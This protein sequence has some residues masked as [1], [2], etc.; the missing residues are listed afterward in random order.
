MSGEAARERYFTALITR[1]MGPL[2]P[3][4]DRPGVTEIMING[5]DEI[6]VEG[7]DD[8]TRLMTLEAG[9]DPE[10]ARFAD[11]A[12]LR[13]LARAILQYSG[14]MLSPHDL[15]QE[16]RL[17]NKARVHIV[18]DPATPK[19]ISIAIRRFPERRLTLEEL[20]GP[21]RALSDEAS[22]WLTEKV[23]TGRNII[24]A[25]GTGT[26]KTTLLNALAG[27]VPNHERIVTIEDV[28]EI[29]LSDDHHVVSMEVQMP[30][31]KGRGGITIRD[32]FRA[33][34][35]MRPDRILVG[36]CRGGE[37]LDMIQAMNSGHAGSLSTVH[38]DS[39][40]RALSRLETLC[41]MADVD[42]PI[43]AV[44]RQL[45]EAVDVVVQIE[46]VR[47]A[48]PDGETKTVR[49]VSEIAEI[50]GPEGA[51]DSGYR[52]ALRT[53]FHRPPGAEPRPLLAR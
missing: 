11:G 9:S 35:R 7:P 8:M 18:Q 12:A 50:A 4:Y 24:I 48:M 25:G 27:T 20:T 43:V 31:A 13:S 33:A 44:R 14:K 6:Y 10:P 52:A 26:G 5:P 30:D 2:A 42:I 22:T 1:L 46:R 17:P 40:V 45:L 32:L 36:E 53:V 51:E 3:Y 39:P 38:A 28:S 15:S 19:G 49:R 21:A 37:A 41:L 23:E 29:D 34:L 16:A 47:L